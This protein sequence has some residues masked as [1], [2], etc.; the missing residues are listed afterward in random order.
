MAKRQEENI[1]QEKEKMYSFQEM[2]QILQVDR[3]TLLEWVQYH[4]I[5]Y[6]RVNEKLVRF[7]MSDI[8]KWV[9]EKNKHKKQKFQFK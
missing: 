2:C 8:E 6:V 4:R 3:R 9:V 1:P 5:P 7:R